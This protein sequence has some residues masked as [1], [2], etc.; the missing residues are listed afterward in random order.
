MPELR[1]GGAVCRRRDSEGLMA[2][3]TVSTCI[4]PEFLFEEF[5]L[6]LPRTGEPAAALW[7]KR[8]DSGEATQVVS[9]VFADTNYLRE[10]ES[11]PAAEDRLREIGLYGLFESH[12]AKL[13]YPL[14]LRDDCG[15]AGL[16]L[17]KAD[18]DRNPEDFKRIGEEQELALRFLLL[19]LRDAV[20][21]Y[22]TT[23]MRHLLEYSYPSVVVDE[24]RRVVLANRQFCDLAGVG[25]EAL[26]GSG[27]ETILEFDMDGDSTSNTPVFMVPISVLMAADI[28]ARS[29]RTPCGT[30]TLFAFKNLRSDDACAQSDICLVQEFSGLALSSDPP[31]KVISLML[32][33]L[34]SAFSCNL[35]CIVRQSKRDELI[36]TPYST[37]RLHS[38]GASVISLEMDPVLRPF[39]ETGSPVV[40]RDV[41]GACGDKSFFRRSLAISSFALL[42][43]EDGQACRNGM[44]MTWQ[45][46]LPDTGYQRVM[47]LNTVA[48]LIGCVLGKAQ[49]LADL[50][51]ERDS[52]RR[53]TK[54][55]AGREVRM[56]QLKSEN[57]QLK[58]LIIDLSGEAPERKQ[59]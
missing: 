42:P 11:I 8:G 50:E 26:V 48:N 16:L 23:M 20:R 25:S 4:H 9:E 34:A 14:W 29:M 13:I 55:V 53:Y 3:C 54:L 19:S 46:A 2:S 18:P 27:L 40:C 22:M 49:L 17:V 1:L 56:A 38:L 28:E 36:V 57:A 39:F 37:R 43:I 12:E 41:A 7:I 33:Y 21:G 58:N 10:M 47:T 32:S 45:S 24:S 51:H 30:R 59:T 6:L 31:A 5:A 15:L 52:L 35:I 44:L